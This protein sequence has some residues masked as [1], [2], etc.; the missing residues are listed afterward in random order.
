MPSSRA[1]GASSSAGEIYRRSRRIAAIGAGSK[2]ISARRNARPLRGA[3][4]RLSSLLRQSV[5]EITAKLLP[6][7]A[8]SLPSR[9]PI[10]RIGLATIQKTRVPLTDA[11][12][13]SPKAEISAPP[14]ARFLNFVESLRLVCYCHTHDEPIDH[15]CFKRSGQSG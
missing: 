8:S 12:A 4:S 13:V 9:T 1:S 7:T 10:P 15:F 5:P 14:S 2:T 6:V 3:H 11:A